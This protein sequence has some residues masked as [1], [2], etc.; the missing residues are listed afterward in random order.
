MVT[1]DNDNNLDEVV[2]AV[3]VG[4]S[5]DKKEHLRNAAKKAGINISCF[6]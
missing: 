1:I 3:P 4:Y 6:I 2:M 5:A